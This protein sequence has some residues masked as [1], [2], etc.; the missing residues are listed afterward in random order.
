MTSVIIK[1]HLSIF[2]TSTI[3]FMILLFYHY[4]DYHLAIVLIVS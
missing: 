1:L 4:K 3:G 2:C